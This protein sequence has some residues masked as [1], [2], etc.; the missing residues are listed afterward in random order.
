MDRASM[1][2]V[3]MSAEVKR[4]H[5]HGGRLTTRAASTRAGVTLQGLRDWARRYPGL[6]LKVGGRWR[7]DAGMLSRILSER[8]APQAGS[9]V[10]SSAGLIERLTVLRDEVAAEEAV[11]TEKVARLRREIA[12]IEAGRQSPD[13]SPRM[14]GG[15]FPAMR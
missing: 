9:V 7:I 14:E 15:G 2:E 11:Q 10:A 4:W 5:D 8:A 6:A 3:G 12:G 1:K 13:G